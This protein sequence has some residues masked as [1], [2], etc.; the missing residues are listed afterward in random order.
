MPEGPV[1]TRRALL[2]RSVGAAVLLL[3]AEFIPGRRSLLDIVAAASTNTLP[4]STFFLYGLPVADPALPA[5]VQ[6][7]TAS[8]AGLGLTSI[9]SELAAAPIRSPDGTRLALISVT[10][11]T[12]KAGAT[13]SVSYVDAKMGAT[14][15]TAVLVLPDLPQGTSLLVT[16]VFAEDSTTLCL[17]LSVTIPSPTGPIRKTDPDTGFVL[18]LDGAIWTSHH[19]IA[20][21]DGVR[22]SF[23]GPF[24][25]DD[26]PALASVNV[27]ATDKDLWLW[28]IDEPISIVK[29][30][31]SDAAPIARLSVFPLGSGQPRLVTAAPGP[32]PVNGEPL[33]PLATG[34]IARLVY[35]SDLQV[36]SSV[37]G[38]AETVVFPQLFVGAKPSEPT[39][40]RRDDGTLFIS[41]PVLGTALIVDPGQEFEVVRQVSY[42]IPLYAAGGRQAVLSPTGDAL[43]VLGDYRIGGS[44]ACYDT[45]SGKLRSSYRSGQQFSSLQLLGSGD[46]VAVGPTSP[47]LGTFTPDLEPIDFADTD[48]DIV[49]LL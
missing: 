1:L 8:G 39:M 11:D 49:A 23:A 36:Y 25:L 21:F 4:P 2:G 22:A 12:D 26:A 42:P 47:K 32:W 6:V 38:T 37:D 43:Y 17:V 7:A 16:P 5:A 40:E 9:A 19:E 10:Q 3:G 29:E 28:T 20:F 45:A 48:I 24:D 15:V 14:T 27:V 34:E 33:L 35:G 46:L 18:Q 44:L 41:A 13:V 30:K 31:G